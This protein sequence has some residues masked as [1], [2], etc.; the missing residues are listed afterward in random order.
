MIID[1]NIIIA[2]LDL[3]YEIPLNLWGDIIKAICHPTAG[4][5]VLLANFFGGGSIPTNRQPVTDQRG[6]LS[7][8]SPSNT[9]PEQGQLVVVDS[10][11]EIIDLVSEGEIEGLV[12]GTWSFEGTKGATGYTTTTPWMGSN[13]FTH[14]IATG[15]SLNSDSAEAK[16]Q[17]KD[18]GFLQSI[19]WNNTPVADKNGFYNF[20][21]IPRGYQKETWRP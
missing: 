13:G 18:L 20:S 21:N 10:D 1:T 17:R 7:G 3:S 11:A 9:D 19:Y 14:Y 16:Q 4:G 5:T 6:V 8:D 12:S 15:S 2:A